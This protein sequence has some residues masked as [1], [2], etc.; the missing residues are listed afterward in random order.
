MVHIKRSRNAGCSLEMV[1]EVMKRLREEDKLHK[2]GK[3]T[4]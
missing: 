1:E 2:T 4:R 3:P